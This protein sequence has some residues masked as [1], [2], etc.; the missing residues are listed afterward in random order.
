[1]PERDRP[2]LQ[3]IEVINALSSLDIVGDHGSGRTHLLTRLGE[4][5][6]GRGYAVIRVE[7]SA[8][9]QSTPMAAL[10][11]LGISV[12]SLQTAFTD[13]LALIGGRP[14]LILVDDWDD[15][16]DIS[17][18]VL[19]RVRLSTGTPI[20]SVRVRGTGRKRTFSATGFTHTYQLRM[21]PRRM[22][23]LGRTL[24]RVVGHEIE[25]ATMAE[26]F[27]ASGGNVG[28]A[29][30]L[31]ETAEREGKIR[32]EDEVAVLNG[33][34]WTPAMTSIIE[35]IL[36]PLDPQ[37]RAHLLT[38]ALL[39]PASLETAILATSREAVEQLADFGFIELYT[40]GT[41]PVIAIR[42]PLLVSYFR[43]ETSNV[44][45][46]LVI[47]DLAE[48]RSAVAVPP[49]TSTDDR[50]TLFI[51]LVHEY[52]QRRLAAAR[53]AWEQAGNR[54]TAAALLAVLGRFANTDG[55]IETLLRDSEALPGTAAGVL[56]WDLWYASYVA[57]VRAD[58]EEA[59]ERLHARAVA[60]PD[61]AAALLLRRA[62]IETLLVRPADVSALPSPADFAPDDAWQ[63]EQARALILLSAGDV[64][65]ALTAITEVRVSHTDS[66]SD[67][68]A[69]IALTGD[70]HYSEARAISEAGL[71]RATTEFDP[72]E[73]YRYA[74]MAAL[75]AF[76]GGRYN[77]AED[78]IGMVVQLVAPIDEGLTHLGI[79]A[80][81]MSITTRRDGMVAEAPRDTV[82]NVSGAFPGMQRAW[83]EAEEL[84]AQGEI[85]AAGDLL[86][87][88]GNRLWEQGFRVGAAYAYLAAAGTDRAPSRLAVLEERVTQVQGRG[89]A[90]YRALMVARV[91]GSIDGLR[92][93]ATKAE[94]DGL[95][96]IALQVW[97]ELANYA[98]EHDD[99]E[100]AAIAEAHEARIRTAFDGP[101]VA[102]SL[103]RLPSNLTDRE[104]EIA[105]LAAAGLTNPEIS[106]M[107]FVSV[108]TVESHLNRVMK[109]AGVQTRTELRDLYR[110]RG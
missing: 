36:Q 82:V 106:D 39:G 54:D 28:L 88:V 18:G 5:F 3:A 32:I 65:G 23:D 17:W 61:S 51:T 92:A 79:Q 21:P 40:A 60:S 96:D 70:G 66:L 1:M 71:H 20:A 105:R 46:M 30:S 63:V 8:A 41:S 38:L 25:A 34:L 45:R 76:L 37:V 80:V 58:P 33:D 29:K 68:V 93:S 72:V 11:W 91:T 35:A 75:A 31:Y 89:I 50:A 84:R 67:L 83:I 62:L 7:G 94:E 12:T 44:R 97:D 77:D 9:F 98:D 102:A 52:E 26:L 24:S 81:A 4:H 56:A 13:L 14:A 16:D 95:W 100:L 55:E 87:E 107:L 108:R 15:V 6:T 103:Q 69:V 99:I 19:S 73:L 42:Q 22:Q 10:G 110:T 48:V 101:G 47:D 53:D 59:M 2:L 78:T 86:T 43:N 85:A 64:E 49:A 27:A 74:Y 90:D 104:R 57:L 109:K